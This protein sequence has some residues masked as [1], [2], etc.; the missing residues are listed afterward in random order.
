MT[1]SEQAKYERFVEHVRACEEFLFQNTT[2]HVLQGDL[3]EA[4]DLIAGFVQFRET[5]D[6]EVII[7]SADSDMFQ[8]LKH[9]NVYIVNPNTDK[10]AEL[11]EYHDSPE[12]YLFQKCIRGDLQSDNI[13][14][15]LP[16]VRSDKLW[17][18][19]NDPFEMTQLLKT[20]WK[21]VNEETVLVEDRFRENQLLIDLEK[22]PDAIR[23]HLRQTIEIERM[24]DA[25][26]NFFQTMKFI[27]RYELNVIRDNIDQYVPMLSS[28]RH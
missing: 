12:Y 2:I 23:D 22:Q 19:F 5:L 1:P 24:R 3:L 25:T 21:N 8:L 14:S 7:L 17:K 9:P 13:P 15:A 20:T 6:E 26:F 11:S 16:R 18:A 27:G 28:P 10:Y 4:D